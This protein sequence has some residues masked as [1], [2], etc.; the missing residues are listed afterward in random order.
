LE[1]SFYINIYSDFSDTPKVYILILPEFG[2]I[3]H[4]IINKRGKE[5]TFGSLGIICHRIFRFY[6]LSP[7]YINLD[8]NTRAY[9]I[10]ATII[11]AIPT[12]IK[13]FK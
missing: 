3:S 11:I 2:L 8:V 9:F 12:G 6:C 4:I 5:E 1:T 10:S 13:I 7:S